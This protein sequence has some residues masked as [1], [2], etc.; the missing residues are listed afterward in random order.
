MNVYDQFYLEGM[1]RCER[2][3]EE[4]DDVWIEMLFVRED[5]MNQLYVCSNCGATKEIIK[6]SHQTRGEFIQNLP[7]RVPCGWLGCEGYALPI[8]IQGKQ[9]P[10]LPDVPKLDLNL[11]HWSPTKN[12]KNINHLG[13]VPG[14]VSLQGEWRPPYVAFSDD[15]I[16][17]WTLSGF[18]WP[19]IDDWDLW[20]L[21]YPTQTSVDGYEICLDTYPDTGRKYIKEY[22]IYSRVYKRDLLY[23]ASRDQ[24]SYGY[25]MARSKK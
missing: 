3:K 21:H 14:R 6:P 17:A 18:M 12:R 2:L 5:L 4:R 19:E 20:Q 10:N 11:F 22:R 25:P 23:V 24:G 16:L 1:S 9:M 8:N 13:L 7:V 15:P